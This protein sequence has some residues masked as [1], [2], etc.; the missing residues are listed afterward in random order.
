[1]E[2]LPFIF[3]TERNYILIGILTGIFAGYCAYI[4]AENAFNP[5]FA[6]A[7]GVDSERLLIAQPDS[8]EN[9]LSIVNSLVGGSV[10]V[11]VVDSVCY[12]SLSFP[13]YISL[14]SKVPCLF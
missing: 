2:V 7:I 9:S 3:I 5:S 14:L 4:D 12:F 8:A 10:A 6:E 1:M 13:V 11:V